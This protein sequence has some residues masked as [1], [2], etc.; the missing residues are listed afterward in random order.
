MEFACK[1]CVHFDQQFKNDAHGV[2]VP[3]WFG[4]CVAGSTY[5]ATELEGQVFP[6]DAR[7]AGGGAKVK[8]VVVQPEEIKTACRSGVH[9]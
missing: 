8:L 6:A 1:D 4:H 3:K 7:R 5:P 9:K 2:P